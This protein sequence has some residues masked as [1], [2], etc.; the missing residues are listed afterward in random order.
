MFMLVSFFLILAD[1]FIL[2]MQIYKFRAFGLFIQRR[3]R[4]SSA[5]APS[6]ENEQSN[7]PRAGSTSAGEPTVLSVF[8]LSMNFFL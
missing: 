4:A 7:S 2:Q 6:R 5:V 3:P 8:Q 1:N